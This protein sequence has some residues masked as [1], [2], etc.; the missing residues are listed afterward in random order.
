MPLL[1]ITLPPPNHTGPH[2]SSEQHGSSGV[3]AGWLGGGSSQR[4]L[5]VSP[6]TCPPSLTRSNFTGRSAQVSG[7]VGPSGGTRPLPT[8]P[9]NSFR[10]TRT[11][12]PMCAPHDACAQHNKRGAR[13]NILLWEHQCTM[14]VLLVLRPDA[15]SC[16]SPQQSRR[17]ISVMGLL[18]SSISSLIPGSLRCRR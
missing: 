5:R 13:Y 6:P 10:L 14:L 17:H 8:P 3:V 4:K 18:S 1:A 15:K 2:V 12:R 11:I 7:G 9:W 16:T